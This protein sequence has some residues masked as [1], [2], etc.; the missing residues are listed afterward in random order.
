VALFT[1]GSY[2]RNVD[3]DSGFLRN[4]GNNV[5]VYTVSV[6]QSELQSLEKQTN[7]SRIREHEA[8]SESFQDLLIGLLMT[9]NYVIISGYD[10][11]KR[12]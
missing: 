6:P 5:N 4:A 2:D 8:D 12:A 11:R 1:N 10:L 7:M 3:Y 9:S